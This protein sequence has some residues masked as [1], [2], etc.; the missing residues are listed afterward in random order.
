MIQRVDNAAITPGHVIDVFFH[1]CFQM[2]LFGCLNLSF[3]YRMTF[4]LIKN[5]QIYGKT[6]VYIANIDIYSS[7]E[8]EFAI[9]WLHSTRDNHITFY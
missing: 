5:T 2:I 7:A 9:C 6:F 4:A 8:H 3:L 1:G